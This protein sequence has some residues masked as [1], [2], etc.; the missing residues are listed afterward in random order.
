MGFEAMK[1]VQIPPE[2]KSFLFA[3]RKHLGKE[4]AY[5]QGKTDVVF[6]WSLFPKGFAG[7]FWEKAP[8]KKKAFWALRRQMV[9][10]S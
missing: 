9:L 2:A 8:G 6:R 4:K 10:P 1:W 5:S 7:A 3:K